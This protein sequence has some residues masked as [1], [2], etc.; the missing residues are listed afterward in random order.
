MSLELF[1]GYFETIGFPRV[2]GDEPPLAVV[3]Q[4]VAGFSPR[5]RG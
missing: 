5:E 2:S 1:D 3:I 4:R